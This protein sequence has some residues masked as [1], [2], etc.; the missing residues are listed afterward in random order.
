MDIL[1]RLSDKQERFID[2]YMVDLNAKQAAIRAGYSKKSAVVIAAE[3]LKKPMI[4][5]YKRQDLS[6]AVL[7]GQTVNTTKKSGSAI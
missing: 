5:V 7:K 1:K 2:E 6:R 4:D 3:N